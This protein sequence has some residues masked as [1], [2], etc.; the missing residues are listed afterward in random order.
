MEPLDI[1]RPASCDVAARWIVP[2]TVGDDNQTEGGWK[3]QAF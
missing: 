1:F 2:V 3:D